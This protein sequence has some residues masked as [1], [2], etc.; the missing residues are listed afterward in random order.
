MRL[1]TY[2]QTSY[3]PTDERCPNPTCS[4]FESAVV[5]DKQSV[6][7]SVSNETPK[8]A[9]AVSFTADQSEW[10]AVVYGKLQRPTFNGK[11]PAF[12]F[13]QS[14]ASGVRKAEDVQ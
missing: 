7:P 6:H 14:V 3:G 1:C 2:C 13:A 8:A 11:G 9:E 4:A 5:H 12:I 10:R